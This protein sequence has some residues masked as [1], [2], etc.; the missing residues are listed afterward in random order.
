MSLAVNAIEVSSARAA[1]CSVSEAGKAHL[2]TSI[3]SGAAITVAT[4]NVVIDCNDFRIGGRQVI[5]QH[6][7]GRIDEVR[8]YNRVITASEITEIMGGGSMVK[9]RRVFT[10][11]FKLALFTD[12]GWTVGVF[13]KGEKPQ[14][15]IL[16]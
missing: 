6:F 1:T 2:N 12:P 5:S 14:L 11:E 8:A 16:P 9:S 10:R 15:Q 4:N 3:T 7:Q 13:A